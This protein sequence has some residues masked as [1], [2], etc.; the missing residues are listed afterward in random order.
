M[1]YRFVHA[2]KNVIIVPK[3]KQIYASRFYG[4]SHTTRCNIFTSKY[5]HNVAFVAKWH[6]RI[7]LKVIEFYVY[8][9]IN[10]RVWHWQPCSREGRKKI[11]YI[12]KI[13]FHILNGILFSLMTK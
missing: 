7:T 9:I 2:T 12:N 4:M 13:Q 3:L 5:M 6:S 8:Y 10:G 1:I 11:V